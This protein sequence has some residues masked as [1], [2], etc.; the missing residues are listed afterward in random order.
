MSQ[1][2]SLPEGNT[3]IGGTAPLLVVNMSPLFRITKRTVG[4]KEFKGVLNSI[5]FP[6]WITKINMFH[7]HR[8]AGLVNECTRNN[9]RVRICLGMESP[10]IDGL[11][12]DCHIVGYI[13]HEI[14]QYV[15]IPTLVGRVP[16][17]FF[18]GAASESAAACEEVGWRPVNT[19]QGRQYLAAP[20]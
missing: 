16:S 8:V 14:S 11:K 6:C 10:K 1:T 20:R 15:P 5:P 19:Q 13:N 12:P 2:V 9:E 4:P 18:P 7:A 17:D 3:L